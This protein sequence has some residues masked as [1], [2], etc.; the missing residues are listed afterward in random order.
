MTAM[1]FF[2]CWI[3]CFAVLW[4]LWQ[5]GMREMAFFRL[6]L[7]VVARNLASVATGLRLRARSQLARF[8]DL[9]SGLPILG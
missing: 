5:F 3:A 9:K 2:V 1:L 7:E 4:A 6:V 8:P